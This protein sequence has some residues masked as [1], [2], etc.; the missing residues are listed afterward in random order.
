MRHPSLPAGSKAPDFELSTVDGVRKSL[1][2]FLAL[3]PLLLAFHRG[4]W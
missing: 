3:G 2:D 1:D 4:T